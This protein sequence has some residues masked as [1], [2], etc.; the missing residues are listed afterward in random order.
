MSAIVEKS[1]TNFVRRWLPYLALAFGSLALGFSGI[2]V[3]WAHAP[4][5]V[6]GF[7]RMVI[8]VAVMAVPFGV[9]VRRRAPVSRRHVWLALLAGLFFAG[10][11]A[12]WNT[13][14][15]YTSAASATLFGNT[16]PLWVSLGALLLFK[17]KLGRGFW[18]GLALALTGAIIIVSATLSNASVSLGSLLAIVAGFFYAGFFLATQRAREG[19]SA[20]SAWWISAAASSGALLIAACVLGQPLWGYSAVTYWNLI[21]L[22]L[23]TQVGGYLAISYA[24]G[25][26][27]ASIVSPTLLGQPVI[28]ALLAIPLLNQPLSPAQIVGGLVVLAGIYVVHRYK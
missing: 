25:H 2:F 13:A 19:L 27:P 8:A 24:L 26:L 6:S 20:M 3:A 28:T 23:I 14:V 1:Q 11:L 7:Y 12:S 17:E 22:A 15:L 9:E 10:D 4:G 18:A 16:S 5:A 21:G